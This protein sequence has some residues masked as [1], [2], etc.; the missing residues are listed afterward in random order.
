[1]FHA[2]L[3]WQALDFCESFHYWIYIYIY[4]IHLNLQA[5]GIGWI[6]YFFFFFK[7][8]LEKKKE[9][10]YILFKIPEWIIQKSKM[11]MWTQNI[12]LNTIPTFVWI[13]WK[14]SNS[15]TNAPC[16]SKPHS[17]VSIQGTEMVVL[18]DLPLPCIQLG[19]ILNTPLI[20]RTHTQP[21]K[22]KT[23]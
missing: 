21:M 18:F 16:G 5:F 14:C 15:R 2:A 13:R 22:Y 11:F 19:P 7:W 3:K 9:K 1:M 12:K 4:I 17:P 20:S 8:K 23:N 10:K 6:F